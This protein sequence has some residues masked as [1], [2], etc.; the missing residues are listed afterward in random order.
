MIPFTAS[1]LWSVIIIIL[2]SILA[3]RYGLVLL[4]EG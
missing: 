2:F 1:L 4:K 3:I